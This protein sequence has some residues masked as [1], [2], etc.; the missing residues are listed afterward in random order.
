MF[1]CCCAEDV[2]DKA[3][4]TFERPSPA[5]ETPISFAERGAPVNNS[6]EA[7]P[8][9]K[10]QEPTDEP[11]RP[12]EEE[13]P[14]AARQ[15]VPPAA[16]PKQP[17][18]AKGLQEV[19]KTKPV[20]IEVKAEEP[21]FVTLERL[22]TSI[23]GVDLSAA[24]KFCMVNSVSDPPSLVG[25]WNAAAEEP[26]RVRRL[27]RLLGINGFS[28]D[29]GKEILEKLRDAKGQVVL[30]FGRPTV[31]EVEVNLATS[32]GLG[33]GLKTGPSFLMVSSI[34]D[35]LVHEYNARVA[36]RHQVKLSSRILAINGKSGKG[37]ELLAVLKEAS[38]PLKLS[39]VYWN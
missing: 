14:G 36:T 1:L 34:E 27:D 23:F 8:V 32:N 6:A 30:E 26:L 11:L 33:L 2:Q 35:G 21:F 13:H 22:P 29:K 9:W 15:A 16:P 37:D 3:Q 39:V 24:G 4:M 31:F 38:G 17:S 12:P 10:Y 20:L 28:S 19:A 5:M 7:V 18:P 25:S